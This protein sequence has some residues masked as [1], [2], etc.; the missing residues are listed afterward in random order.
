MRLFP[1]A[2]TQTNA[3]GEFTLNIDAQAV[4]SSGE[5]IIIMAEKNSQQWKA[6]LTSELQSGSTVQVQ[7]LTVESSGEA[8]VY[9]KL[10]AEGNADLV[11][12]ADVEVYIDT[13]A[14]SEIRSNSQ[15]AAT[16]AEALAAE[17][18]ARAEFYANESAEFSE[19]QAQ[20]IMDA[21][22]QAQLQLEN[23]LNAATSPEEEQEAMQAF[24]QAIVLAHLD[25]GV[26]AELYAKA[27]EMS[28]RV[29]VKHSSDISAEVSSEIR[30]NAALLTSYAIDAAVQTRMQAEGAVESNIQA[31]AD[32]A[33]T[34][35]SDINA[36]TS[37]TKE[38][39]DGAFESYNEAVVAALSQE[40]S[41]SSQTITGINAQI[42]NNAGAKASLES[43]LSATLDLQVLADAYASFYSEVQTIVDETFTS[44]S[45]AE[46][47]FVADVMILVN[48]AN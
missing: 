1:G 42:N 27:K 24:M 25:A 7:P 8:D 15:A 39:I 29:F 5:Q 11:S 46:A 9:T 44:A 4:A 26:D 47:E 18:Q 22:I 35:R 34:L 37:A 36:L 38:D 13:K 6:F 20:Q 17:A 31:A 41:A 16:F 12:K 33:L 23:Q 21:K 30:T 45:E 3:E 48:L 28:N 14:S 43:S 10:I 32:A 19:E 40:F 2:E